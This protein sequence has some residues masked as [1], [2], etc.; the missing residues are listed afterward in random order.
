MKAIRDY[1]QEGEMTTYVASNY[2]YETVLESGKKINLDIWD[3][4]GQERF[5]N[6]N[7]I[8]YKEAKAVLLVYDITKKVTFDEIKN[9]W[10]AEAKERACKNAVLGIIG[11]KSDLF[12]D[13][14]VK[15]EE[16]KAF[17]ESIGAFFMLTS[18]KLGTGIHEALKEAA[19]KIDERGLSQISTG[20]QLGVSVKP[21]K[22]KCCEK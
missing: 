17:A 11:N 12:E 4:A 21:Q 14:E 1:F 3:T 8:F 18:A 9:Y 13:E 2:L 15:E 19:E 16:A 5:R 22:K 20:M 6:V 7:K 10:A